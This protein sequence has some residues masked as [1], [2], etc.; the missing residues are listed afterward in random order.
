VLRGKAGRQWFIRSALISSLPDD[1]INETVMK[2]ADTPVG[3][4]WLFELAGGAIMDFE[5]T[6]IPKSQREALFT[7]AALHQ[8]EM[9]LID[10]VRCVDSA[11]DWIAGTLRP[12]HVGGPFP[13]FLGRHEPPE[14]TKACFGHNWSRLCEVKRFYDPHNLFKNSF[15]P[16][17]T[18]GE[19]VEPQMHEPPTPEF[20][21]TS[22]RG[23]AKRPKLSR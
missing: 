16:L 21:V 3:C 10:D 5:D 19:M 22:L 4:T 20:L 7:I 14:R 11:E 17:N 6:C 15:W 18:D 13:S 2:F 8:W 12:V 23:N 1:I 9:N